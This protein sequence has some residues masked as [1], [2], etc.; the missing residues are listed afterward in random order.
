VDIVLAGKVEAAATLL[1]SL[2]G[3]SSGEAVANVQLNQI[4][5]VIVAPPPV[6]APAIPEQAGQAGPDNYRSRIEALAVRR[7]ISG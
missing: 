5:R 1:R 6:S 2:P 7:V 3:G 4:T